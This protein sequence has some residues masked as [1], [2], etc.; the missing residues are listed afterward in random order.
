MTS[1]AKTNHQVNKY[2]RID[3]LCGKMAQ[4]QVEK[5]LSEFNLLE[6]KVNEALCEKT[7][8][9]SFASEALQNL[10]LFVSEN[11]SSLPAYELRKA[12]SEITKL[13][14][15]LV[16]IEEATRRQGK[17]KFTRT[18]K[19]KP[20]VVSLSD[21]PIISSNQQDK[22][23]DWPAPRPAALLPTLSHLKG[24]TIIIDSQ[25]A[26]NKDVWLDNL[27]KSIV[28]IKGVPSALHITNLS[29][30]KI[31]GGPVQTSVFLEDCR[32]STFVLGCQQMRIHKSQECDFYLHICSR[33]IIEDCST[34]R[35]APYNRY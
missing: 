14:T 11:A 25:E 35:F 15:R 1:E 24:E 34:C 30:C 2:T 18:N 8:N 29:D 23:S 9:T 7:C 28:I 6:K 32:H 21:K 26:S 10:T 31:I 4:H 3:K 19:E 16:E 33:V 22:N 5:F 13:K 17:F 27:E 20:Q 12:H